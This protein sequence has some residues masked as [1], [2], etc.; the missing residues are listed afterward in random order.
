[1]EVVT[2]HG[3]LGP[4]GPANATCVCTCKIADFDRYYH[5]EIPDDTDIQDTGW[6]KV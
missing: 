5:L 4:S 3:N 6:A 2:I 1:M